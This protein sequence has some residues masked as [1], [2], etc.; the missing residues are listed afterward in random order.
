MVINLKKCV[1]G[2]VQVEYLAVQMDPA[3]VGAVLK[4]RTLRLFEGC[5]GF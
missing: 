4:G 5:A 3:K 2:H 1:I